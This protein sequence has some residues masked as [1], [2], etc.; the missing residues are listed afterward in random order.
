[1]GIS[2]LKNEPNKPME[3]EKQAVTAKYGRGPFRAKLTKIMIKRVESKI[4][5]TVS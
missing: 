3:H 2:R 5:L 4:S 1:M